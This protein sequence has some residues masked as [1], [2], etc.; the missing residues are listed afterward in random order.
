V[1]PPPVALFDVVVPARNEKPT[2]AE[3]T[4]AALGARGA[5]RVVVVDHGSSDGTGDA[6]R[7]A[8]A[9]VVRA[10]EGG[11]KGSAL[12]AGV[13]ATESPVLVFLD[14]DLRGL[15]T[16]HV[17]ALAA[18]VLDG[19]AR[20]SLGL[21]DYGSLR[22]T[23]FLRLPPITGLRAL[24]REVFEAIPAERR[25][26]FRIEILINEVV[27]RRRQPFAIRVLPGLHHRSKIAKVGWRAGL[28]AYAA[29]SAELLGCLR[30]VPLW[31]YG[32]YL[33]NLRV[34]PPLSSTFSGGA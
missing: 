21:L 16:E 20:L 30:T 17:E 11:G 22:N 19:T 33:R 12:A 10:A 7:E 3:V 27:A 1:Y 4:R 13:T 5:G 28:P 9:F 23:L 25:R 15:R 31:T 32:A 29:M 2:V 34:L 6:A 18:P 8:G 14:A 24:P 26:G